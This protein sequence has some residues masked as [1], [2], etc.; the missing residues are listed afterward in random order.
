MPITLWT[1]F[2]AIIDDDYVLHPEANAY[3]SSLRSRNRSV[4]TE[5]VY[6]GRIALYLS[7]LRSSDDP[8]GAH[9]RSN[10]SQRS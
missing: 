3:L 10:F 9:R 5:P 1:I 8:I 7:R 2:S 4:N 6:A